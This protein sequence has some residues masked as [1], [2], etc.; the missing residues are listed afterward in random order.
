MLH[1]GSVQLGLWY[2]RPLFD[3]TLYI[4]NLVDLVFASQA[5]CSTIFHQEAALSR[6]RIAGVAGIFAMVLSSKCFIVVCITKM[7]R[8]C[9]RSCCFFEKVNFETLI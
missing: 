6:V 5:K 4:E 8:P 3:V 7:L 9:R 1:A 2:E